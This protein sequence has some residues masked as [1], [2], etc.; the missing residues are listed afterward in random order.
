M[1]R[2]LLLAGIA[3][4]IVVVLTHM[5][6][7]WHILSVMGWGQP[8]SPGHYLDLSSAIFGVALILIALI[9][10]RNSN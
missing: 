2:W 1:R 9:W 6:E 10:R 4:L 8:N 7:R 5:A 3:C